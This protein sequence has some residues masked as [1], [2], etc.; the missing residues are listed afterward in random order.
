MKIYTKPNLVLELNEDDLKVLRDCTQNFNTSIYK[1]TEY[2]ESPKEKSIRL[3]L[4]VEASR[5]LGYDVNDDGSLSRMRED[6]QLKVLLTQ[7]HLHQNHI[8]ANSKVLK[9]N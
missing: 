1:D 3:K 7:D 2:S 4:Y 5:A 6:K 9:K 8:S